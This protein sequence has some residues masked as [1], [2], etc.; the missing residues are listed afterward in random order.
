MTN[1]TLLGKPLE[2]FATPGFNALYAG[3]EAVLYLKTAYEVLKKYPHDML[4][5]EMPDADH[6]QVRLAGYHF[7]TEVLDETTVAF[8]TKSLKIQT[9]WLKVDDYGDKY[10][11]TFLLPEEY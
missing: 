1:L 9:F 2:I 11:G 10:V 4:I 3:L 6:Y 8:K 5:F 7:Q